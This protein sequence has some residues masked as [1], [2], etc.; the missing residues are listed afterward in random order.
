VEIRLSK[1]RQQ[2]MEDL[3]RLGHMQRQEAAQKRKV[4]KLRKEKEELGRKSPEA[5]RK[6]EAKEYKKNLKKRMGGMR[7][8]IIR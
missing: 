1:L 2:A 5:Q 7:S 3:E 6:W 8:K 4:D